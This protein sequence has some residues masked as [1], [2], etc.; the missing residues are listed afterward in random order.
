MLDG[1]CKLLFEVHFTTAKAVLYVQF[2][3]KSMQG[4]A[5][6]ACISVKVTVDFC[7]AVPFLIRVATVVQSSFS[8]SFSVSVP[9]SLSHSHT[10]TC[11]NSAGKDTNVI[12]SIGFLLYTF[13]LSS[14]VS[15]IFDSHDTAAT[16]IQIS[17]KAATS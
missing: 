9:L 13:S 14:S 11:S 3:G 17:A 2:T 8:P 4:G 10:D 1:L 15:A 6:A 5:L 7:C 16:I 12:L